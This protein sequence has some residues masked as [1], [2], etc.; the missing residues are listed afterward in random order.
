MLQKKMC[1]RL[2]NQMFQYAAIRS[3]M[4]INQK[5]DLV[6]SFNDLEKIGF[7]NELDDFNIIKYENKNTIQKD[8]IQK[9]LLL[10][11]DI[12]EKI[13]RIIFIHNKIKY[14]KFCNLFEKKMKKILMKNGIYYINQGYERL[15]PSKKENKVFVGGFESS[16]Y[17][18]TIRNQILLEFTPKYEK[19]E[20]N[21]EMY[22]KIE[23]TESVCVT[24]RRGD[25]LS[26]ENIKTHYVCK[27]DY[28][29]RAIL[30]IQRR[31]EKPKFFV[32]SDDIEWVKNNMQFPE[33]T[34]FEDGTDPVWE[35]LRLMYECKHFIISNSTFS[36]WAQYLS[37]NEK[38]LVI[39]PSRWK[40]TWQN[41][42]I[43]MDNWI[44]LDP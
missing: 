7:K 19:L 36:W 21:I 30:E 10:Y 24:I 2:G 44:L 26:K 33:G 32:F 29:E 27:R 39:A 28:F 11:M 18:D 35:K 13:F 23:N 37:R 25:F 3:Y 12:V 34:V 40:N 42:D 22:E 15:K 43:Y 20:K 1:G 4:E 9:V 38:K 31:I 17:F 5:E 41:K 8:W 14:N 16:K 6:L